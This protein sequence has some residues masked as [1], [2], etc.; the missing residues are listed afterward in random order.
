MERRPTFITNFE[1]TADGRVFGCGKERKTIRRQTYGRKG[2]KSCCVNVIIDG[3]HTTISVAKLVASAFHE[4]YDP[5]KDTI[6]YKDGDSFN[7][8]ADNLIVVKPRDRYRY[9]RVGKMN[10]IKALKREKAKKELEALGLEWGKCSYPGLECTKEGIFRYNGY[11]VNSYVRVMRRKHTEVKHRFLIL[12]E[13]NQDRRKN[14]RLTAAKMVASAWK[15]YNPD[16][17][18][19]IYKDGD[20]TN[21]HADNLKVV[22]ESAY[23]QYTTRN[24]YNHEKSDEDKIAEYKE[25]CRTVLHDT[26]LTLNYL[27]TGNLTAINKYIETDIIPKLESHLK[28]TLRKSEIVVRYVMTTIIELLYIKLDKG[29]PI[30]NYYKFCKKTADRYAKKG[31][32][33]WM[34]ETPETPY[35]KR[36]R[37]EDKELV[38]AELGKKFNVKREYKKHK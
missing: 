7:V 2:G 24:L 32:S 6:I 29:F 5:S 4:G 17:D 25:K 10:R 18:F 11:P 8:A 38:I 34:F 21:I 19:I 3:R 20:P 9:T 33:H 15:F 31:F 13:K 37:M 26:Q 1:V 23:T 27:N 22:G 35:S 12:A 36:V 16:T 30:C 28:Y 14:R